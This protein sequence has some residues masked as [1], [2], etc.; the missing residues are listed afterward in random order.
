[1]V[2]RAK[3]TI[4]I[5]IIVSLLLAGAIVVIAILNFGQP[6]WLIIPFAVLFGLIIILIWATFIIMLKNER[7]DFIP[8]GKHRP[9]DEDAPE[10]KAYDPAKATASK[11]AIYC[12]YCEARMEPD[13]DVCPN[14]KKKKD[15]FAGMKLT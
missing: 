4:F 8:S 10:Y 5:R 6:D 7:A 11:E 1:M 15:R 12:E 2:T 13:E 14:C 9:S 3:K